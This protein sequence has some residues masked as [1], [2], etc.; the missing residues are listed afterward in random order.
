[1]LCAWASIDERGKISGGKAG[2]QT[3]REVR[4]GNMYN[5]G[6]VW[7]IR[8]KNN[9]VAERI[10]KYARAIAENN[11][12]GYDQG[13]RDTLYKISNAAGWT[14]TKVDKKCECDCSQLGACAIN[15]ALRGAYLKSSI[16]SGN[17]VTAAKATGKFNALTIGTNFNYK[18]GD[19]VVRPG[20]H[21]IICIGGDLPEADKK[22]KYEPGKT[23]TLNV[24]LKV[25]AAAGAG[26]KQLK[27]SDLTA[28]GKKHSLDQ[29]YAVLKKGTKVTC[30]E[31][32]EKSGNIWMK[33]P[34]GWI[35][36]YYE[37]K[38]YV[39]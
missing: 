21:V 1:M 10:A 8:A 15:Y 27:R 38:T 20:K 7:T 31:I 12:V 18:K 14:S 32:Q 2:D 5:F 19:I 29:T 33:I 9:E 3:G 22:K 6:Q 16:Y 25:R 11:N 39:N 34:S 17:I 30:K 36:A 35:A 28:D 37:G 23:Y 4:I 13:Q 24:N 26:S